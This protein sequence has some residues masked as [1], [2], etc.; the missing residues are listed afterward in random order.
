MARLVSVLLYLLACLLLSCAA[1][2]GLIAA[3]PLAGR[4]IIAGLG[5]IAFGLGAACACDGKWKRDLGL[6]CTLTAA[7]TLFMALTFACMVATPSFQQ[8]EPHFR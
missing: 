6:V 1:M 2:I 3:F 5:L 8:I 7:Y 4:S